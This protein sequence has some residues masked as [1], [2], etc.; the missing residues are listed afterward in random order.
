MRVVKEVRKVVVSGRNAVD[1]VFED[2]CE[3]LHELLGFGGEAEGF[4]VVGR[5]GEVVEDAGDV[6]FFGEGFCGWDVGSGFEIGVFV[7][8]LLAKLFVEQGEDCYLL[9]EG[10]LDEGETVGFLGVCGGLFVVFSFP[11][12]AASTTFMALALVA[13]VSMM[14]IRL[15]DY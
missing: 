7:L 14:R 15:V 12:V 3:F 2:D 4:V 6:F 13:F 11:L 1:E 5:E 10:P 9:G 8:G